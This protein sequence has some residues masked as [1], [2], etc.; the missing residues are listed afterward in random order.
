MARKKAQTKA[1]KLVKKIKKET[2]LSKTTK[3]WKQQNLQK[4]KNGSFP[5]REPIYNISMR[6]ELKNYDT[7]VIYKDNKEYMRM[8][9]P[10]N[11]PEK[12]SKRKSKVVDD[13][14]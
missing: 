8:T 14:Y 3:T 10:T 6:G 12:V 13:E 9:V 1:Q 2:P 7:W 5:E 11:E 4:V